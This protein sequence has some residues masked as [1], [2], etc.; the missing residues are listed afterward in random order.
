MRKITKMEN[1]LLMI[2]VAIPGTTCMYMYKGL[3][4]KKVTSNN[5]AMKRKR[6]QNEIE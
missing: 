5:N 1:P 2:L 4:R 6:K 3:W